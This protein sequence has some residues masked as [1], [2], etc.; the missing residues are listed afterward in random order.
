M[1][2][3]RRG[4]NGNGGSSKNASV[5]GCVGVCASEVPLEVVIKRR[6]ANVLWTQMIHHK[7]LHVGRVFKDPLQ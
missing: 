3:G 1:S 7:L 4:S 6:A 2:C 5:C